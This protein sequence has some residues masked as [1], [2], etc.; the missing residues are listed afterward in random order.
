MGLARA[1]RG[2]EIMH[3]LAWPDYKR[4]PEEGF[5]TPANTSPAYNPVTQIAAR[6]PPTYGPQGRGRSFSPRRR[7][8][9]CS[10]CLE[11]RSSGAGAVR[12]AARRRRRQEAPACSR[13]V[14]SLQPN[15]KVCL[16]S[17]APSSH[18]LQSAP[19]CIDPIVSHQQCLRRVRLRECSPIGIVESEL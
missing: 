10:C 5:T 8:A 4:G 15:P 16:P 14:T 1:L 11:S 9:G 2:N 12:G 13:L 6:S 17:P 3:G 7:R 19:P 18:H